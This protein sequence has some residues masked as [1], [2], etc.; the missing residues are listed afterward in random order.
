MADWEGGELPSMAPSLGG[1]GRA[2]EGLAFRHRTLHRSR[3]L[4]S[5]DCFRCGLYT[6]QRRMTDSGY[7]DA[8]FHPERNF[9][10]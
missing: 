10:S 5:S 2:G 9:E 6:S 7:G 1:S 4:D 3:G 8:V